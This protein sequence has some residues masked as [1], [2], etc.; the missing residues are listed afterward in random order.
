MG[1]REHGNQGGAVSRGNMRIGWGADSR[2]GE[3][4]S[5]RGPWGDLMVCRGKGDERQCEESNRCWTH[6]DAGEEPAIL[7]D[8]D[9]A[10]CCPPMSLVRLWM[11][12][13]R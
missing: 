11:S 4:G 9:V 10:T 8:V 2:I 1:A 6:E 12:Y 13:S 5:R 3:K 7:G